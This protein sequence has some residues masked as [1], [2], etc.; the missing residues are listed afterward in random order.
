MVDSDRPTCELSGPVDYLQLF[1]VQQREE[2]GGYP[3]AKF[4]E[5]FITAGILST[6]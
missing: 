1:F 4:T 5:A 6:W 2:G 3:L